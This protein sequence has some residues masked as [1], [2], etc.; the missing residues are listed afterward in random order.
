MVE[1]KN[2]WKWGEEVRCLTTVT[3]DGERIHLVTLD[4]RK[5]TKP[6]IHRHIMDKYGIYYTTSMKLNPWAAFL[7]SDLRDAR[8]KSA[9]FKDDPR[10]RTKL[11]G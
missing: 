10:T 8:E 11:G 6:E 9:L 7:L 5:W 2:A 3:R 4:K 1:G